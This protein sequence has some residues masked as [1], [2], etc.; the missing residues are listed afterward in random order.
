MLVKPILRKIECASRTSSA[1]S[2]RFT[3]ICF[4]RIII[5]KI[6]ILMVFS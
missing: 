3:S 1:T 6:R 2:V 4:T 5:P